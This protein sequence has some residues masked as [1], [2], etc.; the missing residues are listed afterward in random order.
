MRIVIYV[1][2]IAFGLYSSGKQRQ[3]WKPLALLIVIILLPVLGR[4]QQAKMAGGEGSPSVRALGD[5]DLLAILGS[6]IPATSTQAAAEIVNRGERMIRL[7]F[8]CKGDQR[9]FT[10]T[11][12][13]GRSR[14]SFYWQFDGP[15][16]ASI[17][18]ETRYH[19][20]YVEVAALYLISAI[21][22]PKSQVRRCTLFDRP[23]DTGFQ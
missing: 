11:N 4:C 14:T 13:G 6:R 17:P 8:K 3:A 18:S 1:E 9:R 21:Y 22:Q 10:G 16:S 2:C 15:D 7:L 20:V 12:L 5:D 23:C 19:V